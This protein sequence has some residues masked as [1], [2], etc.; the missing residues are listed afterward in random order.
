MTELLDFVQIAGRVYQRTDE[1]RMSVPEGYVE[2]QW[3]RDDS[4]TGF[5]AGVY[6]KGDEIVIGFTGSNE[7][8]LKDFAVANIP[9]GLGL[10]SAQIT[11]AATLVL[12][13]MKAY[14]GATISFTGHSLGGGLASVMA[15]FFNKEARVFDPAPFELS[16][17]SIVVL[18]VLNAYLQANGYSN[19][20]L[21]EYVE[22]LGTLFSTRESLVTSWHVEGEILEMLRFGGNT[23]AGSENVLHVGS[24]EVGGVDLH[25]VTLLHALLLSPDF[26]E[27]VATYPHLLEYVFDKNI[28]ARDPQ[29]SNFPDFLTYLVLQQV[30]GGSQGV[31]S[32]KLLEKFAADIQ[33]IGQAGAASNPPLEK[34]LM[35][36]AMD[37]YYNN[38]NAGDKPFFELSSGGLHFSLADTG[39]SDL[40]SLPFLFQAVSST[41]IGGDPFINMGAVGSAVNWHVQTGEGLMIWQDAAGAD[42]V[43]IGGAQG[44]VLR[45]GAGNDF[46]VAGAGADTLDGGA[47]SDTLLGGEG[48]DTLDGGEGNDTLLGGQGADTYSFS[49]A[50]GND[51]IEDADHSGSISIEGLGT[52]NGANAKKTSADSNTWVSE[53]GRL[54]YSVV[55]RGDRQDLIISVNGAEGG[56]SQGRITVQGWTD[57]QLGI[58]LG[59]ATVQEPQGVT[60]VGDFAK[61]TETKIVDGQPK[62]YYLID[63]LNYRNTGKTETGAKD[64]LNG[65]NGN[66]V[67]LG[68]GGNDGLA[69]GNG[70]DW[71]DGGDGDDLILGGYGVDTILG[72]NGND[73]IYGSAGGYV[74]RPVPVDFTPPKAGGTEL[75][76]GFSWVEYSTSDAIWLA[77]TS[78]GRPVPETTGNVI[79]AGAGNDYVD[80]G[81]ADDVVD[82]GD[83]D[84]YLEGMGGNDVIFGGAGND[85]LWGERFDYKTLDY[86]P[87]DMHGNDVI[88][89]GLGNDSLNGG[90]R[91]DLLLGG[92]G[93]DWLGG[94]ANNMDGKLHGDDMLDG[95]AG[96]DTLM[97][98]GGDDMLFGGEGNDTLDGDN[99]KLDKQYHGSDYLEGGAGTD[100][101][102]GGSGDDTLTGGAGQDSLFG[103]AGMDV[104]LFGRGDGQDTIQNQDEGN[105]SAD[106]LRFDASASP[107]DVELRR[108]D[109]DLILTIRGT[110]DSVLVRGYFVN[111]GESASAVERIEF[112]GGTVWMFEDVKALLPVPGAGDDY[113]YGYK[114]DDVLDG[115]AGND[116]LA[117]GL[118]S[119]TYRFGGGYGN[120]TIVEVGNDTAAVDRVLL[121]E[122]VTPADVL[123]T[124]DEG[125]L[126][127]KIKSDGS[128]LTM[129]YWQSGIEQVV[130][131]DG[132]LWSLEDLWSR[133]E[134]MDPTD[135]NDTLIAGS[136]DNVLQGG[137]GNDTLVGEA[138][139][140]TYVFNLGDGHDRIHETAE[141]VDGEVD[142]LQFG[143]G[144]WPGMVR[145]LLGVGQET[146]LTLLIGQ[147]RIDIPNYFVS[148][149]VDGQ[150]VLRASVEEIHFANGVVW[151]LDDVL[152]KGKRNGTDESE[153]LYGASGDDVMNA[154]DGQD[155]VFG[156]DGNDRIRGGGGLDQLFGDS[157]NDYLWGGQGTDQLFGGMGADKLYG[158]AGDDLLYGGQDN[159]SL[160][161]GEGQDVLY[162]EDG[163]DRL[164]GGEDAD[165]LYG[166]QGNDVLNGGGDI[167]YLYGEEGGDRLNGG[168][169]NDFMWADEGNDYLFGGD[170]DDQLHGD[171]GDDHLVG[172]MGADLLMAGNGDDDLSGGDGDD[173]LFGEQGNDSL[174]GGDGNDKLFGDGG[175]NYVSGGN[176]NDELYA[177]AG[178]DTL[179]GGA[180]D[181][182]L[183]AGH[184]NNRLDGGLGN[185]RMSGGDGDDVLTGGDGNDHME[186]GEGSNRLFGGEGNDRMYAGGSDNN[187]SGGAGDDSIFLSGNGNNKIYGGTGNDFIVAG[188]GNDYLSG[189]DGAD[190]L[191]G[192]A[193]DDRVYGGAG[194]D[195]VIGAS[196]NDQLYGGT[197]S[198]VYHLSRGNGRDVVREQ[199]V[200]GADTDVFQFSSVTL[201]Q[202]WFQRNG[203]D[204]Q[205]NIIGTDDQVT[206]NNW[207]SGSQYHIEQIKTSDGK[208]L[209][210]SQVDQL[211]QAMAGFAPPAAGE[212]TLPQSYQPTLV[213]VLA[214]NWS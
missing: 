211:V 184:G 52:L 77:G 180:G 101:L 107:A 150:T 72:G 195:T 29:K 143:T 49:G 76:R 123:L 88:D 162:G 182:L 201:E 87:E 57:G 25:S 151:T 114:T 91:D 108:N 67:I 90:G 190:F 55:Q 141:Q 39:T 183:H 89:G 17:K 96:D 98:H 109:D 73:W 105:E 33:K 43:V 75:T 165:I 62:E 189:G 192:N 5:S 1:N 81:Y 48:A 120:D 177:D 127:L 188:N 209:L 95:G 122:G 145:V 175:N 69:G 18:E 99:P 197:G 139:S 11:Q 14:P 202:L 198:D 23:I 31:E 61:D 40:K 47:G 115:G 200:S 59:E 70:D 44:D 207:Y 125:H 24:P 84:D 176:G 168:A 42:D 28:Y 106:T 30:G 152:A 82:G 135:G 196:G 16:A 85:N 173:K 147:D 149:E 193:G 60:L 156:R 206:V 186:A 26:K 171:D 54:S 93:N 181:D 102:R 19:A 119:D 78:T 128:V 213:P 167:D 9:A 185:D 138:G 94:D 46:L 214:A 118:G 35:V 179:L 116:R 121:P 3:Q 68:L 34:A 144:I 66:D 191:L 131:A 187:V 155:L 133:A 194:N 58:S 163:N 15:V 22:S 126:Y 6:K 130:F 157:G 132:T 111:D 129:P 166:G 92:E 50:F 136:G 172:D 112:A 97:G 7:E 37:Y 71:L 36:A 208:T 140:D 170:G 113:V 32:N 83:G 158:E 210:D 134:A 142:V 148:E 203:N 205:I 100:T 2:L 51:V 65:G 27:A 178:D 45:A 86:T 160:H 199:D 153:N 56:G 169:G 53:D 174:Y 159:D 4:L 13:V 146:Q 80:A 38:K 79:D 137:R 110:A 124:R 10:S 41:A 63:G 117:G 64:V 154:G 164:E 20:E 104:Y 161:G 74:D 21:N 212:T 12:D 204:L 103:G 8:L